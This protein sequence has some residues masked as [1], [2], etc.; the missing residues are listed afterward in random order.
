V[1][2]LI[3]NIIAVNYAPGHGEVDVT[4]SCGAESIVC[5]LSD[6]RKGIPEQER[7]H[8]LQRFYRV[9]TPQA[10][11]TRLG[12]AIAAATAPQSR[13]RLRSIRPK[14][15]R[16]CWFEIALSRAHAVAGT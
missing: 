16:A 5:A 9:G 12:L 2:L 10:Q 1:R 3:G 6:S 8:V 15:G 7:G 4:L 13:A 11:R 14:A